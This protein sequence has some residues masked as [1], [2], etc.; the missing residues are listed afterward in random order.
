MD[1]I[2]KMNEA[3]D[4]IEEN[5]TSDSFTRAFKD[6]HGITPTDAREN[7]NSLKA[8][9][10]MTFQ[11]TVEGGLAM[12]YRIVK[13][14]SFKIV[15]IKKRVNIVFE[16][17]NPE[18]SAMA[19]SLDDNLIETL[20][21]LSNVEPAGIINASANFSEGR[22]EEKGKLDHYIGVATTKNPPEELA[23]LEVPASTWAVFEV[24]G[25]FPDTLQD[26]WGRIYSEWF[27]SSNYELAEGPEMLWNEGGDTEKP[28]YKSEIWLPVQKRITE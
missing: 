12:D 9:P 3:L 22:M 10:K 19:E 7:I 23:L 24:V 27:P 15:G 6:F 28:D 11:I 20:L 26:V 1:S 13:K 21:D 18:I 4:Y 16:G 25:S 17:E 14:E 2:K 5:L 8:F